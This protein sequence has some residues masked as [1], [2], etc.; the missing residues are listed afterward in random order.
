MQN[1]T[2]RNNIIIASC[3]V[4][5]IV[6]SIF[7]LQAFQHRTEQSVNQNIIP[8]PVPQS[9]PP[10]NSKG[11]NVV[12]V[13]TVE[14]LAE[15][16]RKTQPGLLAHIELQ[17]DPPMT[18]IDENAYKNTVQRA[19]LSVAVNKAAWNNMTDEQKQSLLNDYIQNL[20]INSHV[21]PT[22]TITDTQGN[23]IAIG[24]P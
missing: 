15:V 9:A 21:A 16:T 8:T 20:Q 1:N 23:P 2:L 24:H 12:A 7:V 4:F 17:L 19:K 11:N 6:I 5:L 22:V 3:I 18:Q 14:Q 13:E 10:S